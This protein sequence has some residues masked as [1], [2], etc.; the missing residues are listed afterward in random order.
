MTPPPGWQALLQE[1]LDRD[2]RSNPP[3]VPDG[4]D[5]DAVGR[6]LLGLDRLAPSAPPAGLAARITASLHEEVR[7]RRRHRR[8][9]F[10]P[11]AGLVAAASLLLL[12]GMRLAWPTRDDSPPPTVTLAEP[13]RD[14]IGR[15]G[16]A[17]TSLTAR[18]AETTVENT[19]SLLPLVSTPALPP[20]PEIEPPLE[21]FL[22]ASTGVATGLA[23]VTDSAGRAVRL[24]MRD[25]PFRSTPHKPG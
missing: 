10:A 4:L 21:P 24:F 5:R 9:R 12:L 11:A 22:E 18:S 16:T 3:E 15:A 14:S 25:L 23:P 19:S 8:W 13:F 2:G 1:Y 20:M 6:L 17:I 7:A